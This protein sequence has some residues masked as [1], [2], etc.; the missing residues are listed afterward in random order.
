MDR[1][2]LKKKPNDELE[3]I[4]V[5]SYHPTQIL[6]QALPSVTGY[7]EIYQVN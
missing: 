1:I 3:Y 2:D 7:Q 5:L 6:K 4:N